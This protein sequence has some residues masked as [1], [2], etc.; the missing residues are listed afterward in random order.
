M[1]SI[2]IVC[3]KD[4]EKDQ[5]TYDKSK[6]STGHELVIQ[7]EQWFMNTEK[8]FKTVKESLENYFDTIK[9]K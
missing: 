3:R 5:K 7:A 2:E 8:F 9:K 1:S 6:T 4:I